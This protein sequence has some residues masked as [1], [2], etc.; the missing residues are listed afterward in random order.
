M[1]TITFKD[2]LK[3]FIL[4]IVLFFIMLVSIFSYFTYQYNNSINH[5]LED[6]TKQYEEIGRAHV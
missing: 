4:L 1:I 2:F 3:K 6:L 5:Y